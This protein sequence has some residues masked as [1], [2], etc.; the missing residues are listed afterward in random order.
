MWENAHSSYLCILGLLSHREQTELRARQANRLH[1]HWLCSREQVCLKRSDPVW[2]LGSS[3][4]PVFEIFLNGL[5]N[6]SPSTKNTGHFQS[7]LPKETKGSIRQL[8]G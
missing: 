6:N 8:Q 1:F 4:L 7:Q 5:I 3:F 2:H